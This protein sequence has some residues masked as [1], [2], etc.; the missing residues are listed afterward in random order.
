MVK[1]GEVWLAALDP[2]VGSEIQKTRPCLI[3]SPDEINDHLRTA[4]VAPMTTGSRPAPFR[5]NVRFKGK[6]GLIVLDQIRTLDKTRLVKRM[7]RVDRGT[8][9]A[10]LGVLGEMFGV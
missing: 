6:D 3:I 5:V 4:I 9:S 10:V 1:R 8:L 7:G 2:T